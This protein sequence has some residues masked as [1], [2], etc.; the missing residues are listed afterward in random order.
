[1]KLAVGKHIKIK[2]KSCQPRRKTSEVERTLQESTKR[3]PLL[4]ITDK[5][6]E[7]I[8]K[9]QQDNELG[10]YMESELNTV[11]KTI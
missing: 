3:P 5:P 10:H 2:T 6:T 9:G 7:E 1:M 4:E 8:I 11:L